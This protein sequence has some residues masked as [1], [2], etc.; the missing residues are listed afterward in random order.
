MKAA[1]SSGCMDRCSAFG[2]SSAAFWWCVWGGSAIVP[3]WR[4]AGWHTRPKRVEGL[5]CT[6]QVNA[7]QK[8]CVQCTPPRSG[9]SRHI[10]AQLLGSKAKSC[11]LLQLHA[12]P[13]GASQLAEAASQQ[14]TNATLCTGDLHPQT[15]EAPPTAQPTCHR[16]ATCRRPRK[17]APCTARGGALTERL[18][19]LGGRR[20]CWCIAQTHSCTRL[21]P[22]PSGPRM[23]SSAPQAAKRRQS[24]SH[25]TL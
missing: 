18:D 23:R 21:E 5:L 25:P 14:C 11:A 1:T 13:A 12:K 7:G 4:L 2:D 6:L 15:A 16:R 10:R 3:V 9:R 22:S 8:R 20:K 17:E 24:Q 19:G